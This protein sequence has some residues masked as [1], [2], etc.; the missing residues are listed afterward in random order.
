LKKLRAKYCYNIITSQENAI[1]PQILDKVKTY[2][3]SIRKEETVGSRITR[4]SQRLKDK[5]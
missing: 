4:Q 2:H 1:A 5:A 3:N